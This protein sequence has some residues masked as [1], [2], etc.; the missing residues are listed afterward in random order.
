MTHLTKDP[1]D[2]T[3]D[4][5]YRSGPIK[6]LI[7]DRR[8]VGLQEMAVGLIRWVN[9]VASELEIFRAAFC[10]VATEKSWIQA[11]E[12][13]DCWRYFH[14]LGPDFDQ[15]DKMMTSL[16]VM[17]L[18]DIKTWKTVR[19]V[20]LNCILE[21]FLKDYENK[22]KVAKTFA[23]HY[24]TI[25]DNVEKDDHDHKYSTASITVQL[26]TVP[27]VTRHLIEHHS[28]LGPAVE[29]WFRFLSF[30]VSSN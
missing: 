26:F 17:L 19:R 6:T 10:E 21:L 5:N 12:P 29:V 24:T 7:I 1:T 14:D 9:Q 18:S 28:L 3:R 11:A 13:A 20:I 2:F 25:Y 15:Y 4:R 23:D 8:I 30:D 22:L 16:E 27:T